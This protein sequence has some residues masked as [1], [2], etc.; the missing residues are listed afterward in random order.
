MSSYIGTADRPDRAKAIAAVILVH[1]ALAAAILSGLNV[2]IASEAVERMTT[3]DVREP[4]PPPIEPPP[5][6]SPQPQKAKLEEGAAGRKAEPSP[7]V[8]PQPQIPLR[9]PLPAA[10]IAG[11]ASATTAGAANYGTGTGAGGSGVGRGGGGTGDFSGYTP[12][13]QLTRIPDREYRRIAAESGIPA[14]RASLVFQVGPNGRVYNCR[15]TRSSGNAAADVLLCQLTT[16]YVRFSPARDPSGK[17][18][19]QDKSY[20]PGWHPNRW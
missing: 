4:P 11:R 8:A 20:S 12:A 6:P 2:R 16:Q 19:W 5:R 13:R 10:P 1:A 7:I 3:I 17:P 18:V 9:S 15:V 14:G